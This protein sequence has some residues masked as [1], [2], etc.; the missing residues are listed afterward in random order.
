MNPIESL[1]HAV[2]SI[3]MPEGWAR[4]EY[5]RL[6]DED[7]S[8]ESLV[9]VLGKGSRPNSIRVGYFYQGDNGKIIPLPSNAVYEL[10]VAE[11]IHLSS[12]EATSM[13]IGRKR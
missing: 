11:I 6:A 13:G 8:A 1:A 9:K 3:G 4:L 12:E 5:A 2:L 7:F 10:K